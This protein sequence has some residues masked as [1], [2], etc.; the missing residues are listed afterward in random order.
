MLK[1]KVKSNMT[2]NNNLFLLFFL[3][4]FSN[5]ILAQEKCQFEIIDTFYCD[6]A[7]LY[8][9]KENNKIVQYIDFS[10]NNVLDSTTLYNLIQQRKIGIYLPPH[11]FNVLILQSE[12]YFW[13]STRSNNKY[14]FIEI[15]KFPTYKVF[16]GKNKVEYVKFTLSGAN[17]SD[18]SYANF[19]KF[20]DIDCL[21]IYS[22]LNYELE[23]VKSPLDADHPPK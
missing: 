2:S 12:K 4:I 3:V 10:T 14:D 15:L 9:I 5:N 16:K 18:Y 17:L 19:K 13:R 1:R 21:L 22:S 11:L 6:T 23:L 7:Y 8:N 20:K